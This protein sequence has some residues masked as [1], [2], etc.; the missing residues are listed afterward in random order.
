MTVAK[1]ST[2]YPLHN[3]A[4][5]HNHYDD[6]VKMEDV[7]DATILH[8]LTLR[9]SNDLVYTNIGTILVSVNPF[10]W[11]TDLYSTEVAREHMMTTAGELATPHVFAIGGAAFRGMLEGN[12]QSII[13][14][15][16]SGAGKTEATKQCLHF[17]VEITRKRAENAS[18]AAAGA[19]SAGA[20]G[21]GSGAASSRR[22]PTGSG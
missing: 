21:A 5:I 2:T 18:G 16:E 22:R 9:F 8:N 10:K 17:F 7:N 20:A 13:I 11:I 12:D 1:G 14:S 15:G 4:S 6:M 19:S 3:V